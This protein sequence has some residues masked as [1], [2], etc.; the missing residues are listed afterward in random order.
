MPS[1]DPASPPRRDHTAA[2]WISLK[3]STSPARA[4]SSSS[5]I[6]SSAMVRLGVELVERRLRAPCHERA[7][8]APDRSASMCWR[9]GRHQA[10]V[11]A[12]APPIADPTPTAPLEGALPCWAR[13]SR[14]LSPQLLPTASTTVPAQVG[15]QLRSSSNH[16]WPSTLLS[17]ARVARALPS[18][19]PQRCLRCDPPSRPAKCTGPCRTPQLALGELSEPSNREEALAVG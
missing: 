16:C 12:P 9:L 14:R 11:V 4:N 7:A 10:A 1:T 19:T 8:A 5:K 18:Q 6:V 13:R 2:P 17:S 3:V 15:P